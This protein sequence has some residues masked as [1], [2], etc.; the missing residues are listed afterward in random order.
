MAFL[1]GLGA[2]YQHIFATHLFICTPVCPSHSYFIDAERAYSCHVYV[3]F[4]LS[5]PDFCW[6]IP[7]AA[8]IDLFLAL[9]VTMSL[10]LAN[11]QV[12]YFALAV[13][14][15][16]NCVERAARRASNVYSGRIEHY[17]TT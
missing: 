7:A 13:Y 3:P 8:T 17:T 16:S 10:D 9:D 2:I 4:V 1:D 12:L 14:D 11:E 5:L 6:C 15:R